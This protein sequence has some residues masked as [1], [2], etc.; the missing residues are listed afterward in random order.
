[1]THSPELV[2]LSSPSRSLR[3]Y[4]HASPEVRRAPAAIWLHGSEPDPGAADTLAEFYRAR[5]YVLLVPHRAGHGESPGDYPI[6]ELR[7]RL[8][9]ESRDGA[10]EARRLA[11]EVI[12]LHEDALAQT[13]AAFDWLAARPE[14][15]STR[16]HIAGV[17]HGAIQALLAAE[18]DVG[19]CAYVGFAPG[20]MAWD[21]VPGIRARL[22]DAV[23]GARRPIL[24]VQAANDF[25]LGPSEELGPEL[26]RK[27]E[28]NAARVYPA[29]G[30]DAQAGHGAFATEASGVWG[31]DL[32][33]FVERAEAVGPDGGRG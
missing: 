24:L 19:A 29:Y 5:G 1:M 4:L 11:E 23:R 16:V 18:A 9:T 22:A 30:S 32:W 28:P 33:R 17:S 13:R 12:A 14:V 31:A 27:G 10:V 21:A 26:E 15:D 20:A 3:A 7:D 8:T 6:A 2:S 25:S